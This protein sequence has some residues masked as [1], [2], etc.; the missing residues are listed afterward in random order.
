MEEVI[1]NLSCGFQMVQALDALEQG[2]VEVF[3][4]KGREGGG[5]KLGSG[6]GGER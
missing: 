4:L 6:G 2:V 1:G 5:I 3:E